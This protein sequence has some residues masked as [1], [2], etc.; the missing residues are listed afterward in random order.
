MVD[1]ARKRSAYFSPEERAR[2]ISE[3]VPQVKRV[4]RQLGRRLP[5]RVDIDDLISAG[6]VGLVE[7]VDRFDPEKCGSLSHYAEIRIRGAM[8]D[9]LRAMD[10][11]TRSLRRMASRVQEA[12]VRLAQEL[13][14]TPEAEDLAKDL[15]MELEEYHRMM[16]RI[17]PVLVLSFEDLVSF[18]DE[19]RRDPMQYL[20]DPSAVDPASMLQLK[21]LRAILQAEIRKM[22][23]RE[24]LVVNLYHFEHMTLK[25]IGEIL[26]VTES[27]VSQILSSTVRQLRA[28][29]QK[30]IRHEGRQLDT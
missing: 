27:R 12:V 16:K 10:W 9:E 29:I 2:R 17:R 13:G 14:R 7:A 18:A 30:K 24:R 19:D 4:A 26:G 28:R 21:R 3:L 8:L 25:Q 5:S 15:G 6:T 23:E 1:S 22:D 20:Q 11:A